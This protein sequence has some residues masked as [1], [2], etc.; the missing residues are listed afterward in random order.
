MGS[1]ARFYV[2]GGSPD[3]EARLRSRLAD[4]EQRWSRFLPDSEVSRANANAGR[5]TTV[6]A[7]T[8]LLAAQALRAGELTHGWFDPLLLEPLAD[9][10]YERS[11]DLL[12]TA[13]LDPLVASVDR[14]GPTVSVLVRPPD[15]GSGSLAVDEAAGTVT[16]GAGAGFDPGGIGKGLA[17]D[18]LATDAVAGGA[19]A[20]MIDL[21][22]DIACA[23]RA[24]AA[25]WLVDIH[26]PFDPEQPCAQVRIPWGAVATS[27]SAHRRWRHHGEVAHQ[28]I[29]PQTRRPSDSSIVQAT[30][31]AGACWLAE[32]SAKAAL[33]AGPIAGPALLADIGVEGLL[34]C[35]DG[36]RIETRG[37][38][39]FTAASMS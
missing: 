30:V 26:D 19:S 5:P 10:G 31:I 13:G 16:V 38:S 23:G 1:T 11:Y 37:W 18:L 28:L 29:D 22:G 33:L 14:R 3:V 8:R 36:S 39:A 9:A 32:V 4:L 25:G 35:S 17:A 34:M 2:C 7:E 21:G 15:N 27:S 20:V 24:P 6:S 12:D